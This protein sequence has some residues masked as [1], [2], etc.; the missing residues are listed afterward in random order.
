MVH[1]L[2]GSTVT[3]QRFGRSVGEMMRFGRIIVVVVIAV[4]V[5]SAVVAIAAAATFDGGAGGQQTPS[6]PP[7]ATS[8]TARANRRAARRDAASLLTKLKL[9]AGATSV[10]SEP[11]H[12][13]GYLQPQPLLE[14]EFASA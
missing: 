5:A 14:E 9:P 10:S 2:T 1:I 11:A 6:R 3:R 12:D 13:H 4:V 7:P 8:P